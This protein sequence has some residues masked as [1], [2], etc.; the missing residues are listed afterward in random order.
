MTDKAPRIIASIAT[1]GFPVLLLVGFV[2]HPNLFSPSLTTTAD[3]LI[4]KFRGNP[5]FHLGHLIVLAAV[6]LIILSLSYL[7]NRLTGAGRSWGIVGG[8]A[9]MFG[10][11]L[12]AAD[13]G[14]LCTVL[15]AF[16]TLNDADFQSIRPAL[17]AIVERQGL[18]FIFWA[19]PLLPLGAIMQMIGL[20][21]ERL[22]SRSGG[23]VAIAGL[24]LLNNPDIDIASSLGAL[25]MCFTY[26]PL[27]LRIAKIE[28]EIEM[29]A[30][31]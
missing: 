1:I 21:K 31:A 7:S 22:V 12:L 14:A 25:L 20:M 19:L 24:A 23:I 4:A 29:L 27:G 9:A 17:T 26:I 6:P 8:T 28:P 13:K 2:L 5:A 10:A 16:D 11:A 15:S 3:D 18:L 30:R